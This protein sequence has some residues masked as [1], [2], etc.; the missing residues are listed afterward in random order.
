M[1]LGVAR[2]HHLERHGPVQSDVEPAVHRGHAAGGDH[3]VDAVPTV[4]HRTDERVRS[5]AGLHV[6]IL[7]SNL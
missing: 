7:D 1:V 4:Q 2:V 6:R 3:G 5:L